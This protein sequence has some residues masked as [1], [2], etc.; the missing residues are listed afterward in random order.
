LN[1]VVVVVDTRG[2]RCDYI[3]FVLSVCQ[4]GCA[5]MSPWSEGEQVYVLRGS[6]I[7]LMHAVRGSNFYCA[8]N[9][10]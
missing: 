8:W 7:L 5:C 10:C 9:S 4:F 2:V 3:W 1:T 6:T